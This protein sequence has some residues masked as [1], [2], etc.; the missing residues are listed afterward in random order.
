MSYEKIHDSSH[1]NAELDRLCKDVEACYENYEK[2]L[3]D[4]QMGIGVTPSDI[5]YYYKGLLSFYKSYKKVLR[6]TIKNS[7]SAKDEKEKEGIYKGVWLCF[8]EYPYDNEDS[9]DEDY[10]DYN[11]QLRKEVINSYHSRYNFLCEKIEEHCR[12]FG[13]K[14]LEDVSD[15]GNIYIN[16]CCQDYFINEALN[17]DETRNLFY[18]MV[19]DWL[20]EAEEDNNPNTI[21]EWKEYDL[22]KLKEAYGPN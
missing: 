21:V 8:D 18:K 19:T 13:G 11:E 10:L 9:A 3:Y 17:L 2:A 5:N 15:E 1:P 22:D 20:N 4:R 12:T 7:D 16:I 6:E 14:L